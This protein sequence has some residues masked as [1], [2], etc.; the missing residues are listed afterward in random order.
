VT[1]AG[2]T[3]LGVGRLKIEVGSWKLEVGRLKVEKNLKI[4]AF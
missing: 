1:I 4:A 2:C 3:K